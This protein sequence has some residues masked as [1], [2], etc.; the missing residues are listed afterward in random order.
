MP[1]NITEI[2]NHERQYEKLKIDKEINREAT[3]KLMQVKDT[4]YNPP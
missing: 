4:I 3:L 1:I 2:Y